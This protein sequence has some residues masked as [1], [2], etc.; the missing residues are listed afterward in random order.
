VILGV[1]GVDTDV[2]IAWAMR[3]HPRHFAARRLFQ[4]ETQR[5]GNLL[6]LAPQILQEFLHVATDARRFENPF[7]FQEAIR[8][9]R[10]LWNA[11][12]VARV[13][14]GPEVLPRTLELMEALRLGRKRILDTTFAATL[15][16]AG[17]RRIA[18]F[19]TSDFAIFPFLETADIPQAS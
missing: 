13:L 6:G 7:P 19:N 3:G 2:L 9:A 5:Q 14:P 17:V 16:A 18:T 8:I 10:G 1:D 15:E 12:E 11:R 4:E